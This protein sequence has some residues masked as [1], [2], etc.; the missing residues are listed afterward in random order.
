MMILI[1]NR[2][3]ALIDLHALGDAASLY[4]FENGNWC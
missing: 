1:V 4:Q 2:P 3:A